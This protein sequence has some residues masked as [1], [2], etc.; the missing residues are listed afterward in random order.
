LS[1]I[2]ALTEACKLVPNVMLLGSLPESEVEA[3]SQ[4]GVAALRALEKTFGRIQALWKPVA[5]EE[6]F[7]IVRRRLFEPVRD[8]KA[9]EAVCRAFADAYIAEG[10]RLLS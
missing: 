8:E 10:A 3:G 2:Q 5:T 6:A 1:F 4:R 9:R 7:E